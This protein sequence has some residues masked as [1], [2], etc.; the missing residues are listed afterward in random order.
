MIDKIYEQTTRKTLHVQDAEQVKQLNLM[1]RGWAN[2]F[3]L[4]PV[5]SSY[6]VIDAY[7]KKRLRRWLGKKHKKVTGAYACYPDKYLYRQLGLVCL[8]ELTKRLPWAKA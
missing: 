8:P 7:T 1:L 2:Y 5:S 3:S 6:R 4:G